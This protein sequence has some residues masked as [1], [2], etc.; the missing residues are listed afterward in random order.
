M[1]SILVAQK[2]IDRYR[3]Q[4]A[5][6]EY[7][8]LPSSQSSSPSREQEREA[9]VVLL[10]EHQQGGSSRRR[11]QRPSR[12]LDR[13]KAVSRQQRHSSNHKHQSSTSSNITST[14]TTTHS[15]APPPTAEMHALSH[16]KSK[17]LDTHTPP[18]NDSTTASVPPEIHTHNLTGIY[19]LNRTLS[20]DSQQVLKMQQ[21]GFLVRQA[22]AYSTVT[23]TLQQYTDDTSGQ[24][25]LDQEQLSTGGI[26]N[27]ED[28]VMDWEWTVKENWIWGKV[29]GR[30]RYTRL[31]EIEDPFLKEGWENDSSGDGGGKG[32][33]VEG[34]VES[35]ADGWTA[36]QVWGFAEVE[37]QR[38][39]VRRILS[40]KPRWEDQR[41]RMV[42]DWK[43]PA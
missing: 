8:S 16:L 24:K 29:K 23:V 32:E 34:Y 26:R 14:T 22:V 31:A 37:G 6:R 12:H 15:E 41:I 17:V 28:R 30:S 33:V 27:F 38:R 25:H 3:E 2:I 7:L 11:S 20:D 9:P 39:H 21:I 5:Q 42:Y 36:R 13:N 19:T 43:G 18:E 10:V 1:E 35:V 40:T 4:K